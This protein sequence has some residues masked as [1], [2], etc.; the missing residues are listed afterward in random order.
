MPFAIEFEMST[1]LW[2][3]FLVHGYHIFLFA[4]GD[5]FERQASQQVTMDGLTHSIGTPDLL[6]RLPRI[7]RLL[8][9]SLLFIF[10]LTILP[11]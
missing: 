6:S 8:A 3:W 5:N 9:A 11:P 1:W 4:K 10:L 2:L 7:T